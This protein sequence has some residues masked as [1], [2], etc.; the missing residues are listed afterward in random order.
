ML[1]GA[2]GKAIAA[3]RRALE[4][5]PEMTPARNNLALAYVVAGEPEAARAALAHGGNRAAQL[6]NTG[7]VHLARREYR[8][9]VSAFAAAH[10]LQP[11]LTRAGTRARQAAA[12]AAQAGE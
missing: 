6:Y 9:A 10:A 1:D 2:P 4:I 5:D 3:C 11:T 12:L 8:S 7:I